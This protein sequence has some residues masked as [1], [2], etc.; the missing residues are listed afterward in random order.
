MTKDLAEFYGFTGNPEH[1]RKQ[2]ARIIDEV[3]ADNFD[4][5]YPLDY[6]EKIPY[7]DPDYRD[8]VNQEVRSINAK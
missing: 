5:D 6:D 7:P 3:G 4:I 1:D 2:K 8:Y